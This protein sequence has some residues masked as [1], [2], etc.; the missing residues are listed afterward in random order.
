MRAFLARHRR[1]FLTALC[2]I[3]GIAMAVSV[4]RAL[5]SPPRDAEPDTAPVYGLPAPPVT[6]SD[7]AIAAMIE[8]RKLVEH[9]A[10]RVFFKG[11]ATREWGTFCKTRHGMLSVH[12]VT[13]NGIPAHGPKLTP[14]LELKASDF[15]F[16]TFDP[17]TDPAAIPAIRPGATYW[18]IGYPAGDT[19]G[20]V[21]RVRAYTTDITPI[22]YWFAIEEQA[23]GIGPEGVLG[24]ISGSCLVDEAGAVVAV[25]Y[26]NGF[27]KLVE[28]D[29]WA[30]ANPIRSALREAQGAVPSAVLSLPRG[31]VPVVALGALAMNRQ[32]G[33]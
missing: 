2:A 14:T 33:Q 7:E 30:L 12:H 25:V 18:I 32:S 16:L 1:L 8:K 5:V 28:G 21:I 27:S 24:G 15:A 20:E 29:T 9:Y 11:D 13:V 19:D 4:L 10:E 17:E 23:P 31:D 26:A 3:I 6:L 22:G